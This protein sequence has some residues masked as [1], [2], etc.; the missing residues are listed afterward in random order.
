M[1]KTTQKFSIAILVTKIL[2][3]ALTHS[4]SGIRYP[5]I[6][7][8]DGLHTVAFIICTQ[9]EFNSIHVSHI[10]RRALHEPNCLQAECN[11]PILLFYCWVYLVVNGFNSI[12]SL[13]LN[14]KPDC[15][16]FLLFF[17]LNVSCLCMSLILFCNR[18]TVFL[19]NRKCQHKPLFIDGNQMW[20]TS[21]VYARP[22]NAS[23]IAVCHFAW[24]E[25]EIFRI[26]RIGYCNQFFF[27]LVHN[28]FDGIVCERNTISPSP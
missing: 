18:I 22:T 7:L 9:V 17:V 3:S 5:M 12:R 8:S 6:E 11:G 25:T 15:F 2:S 13:N 24:W 23:V 14:D 26:V 16:S 20:N 10:R 19:I 27:S 28:S 4:F 21:C 1:T